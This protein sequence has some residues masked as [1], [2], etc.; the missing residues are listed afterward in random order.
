MTST[1][2]EKHAGQMRA[3]VHERYGPPDVLHVELVAQPSPGPDQLLVEVHACTVN[4]T[5]C[6]FRAAKPFIVRFFSGL[7]RPKKRILGTEFAGVVEAVGGAVTD[8]AVGDRVFGVNADV[9]GTQAEYV[10]VNQDAPV[11][12]MPAGVSFAEAAAL[13]D[14]AILALAYLRQAA[15]GPST[16]IVVYGASG[17]IGSAAVQL[18]KHFGAE[19]TAVCGA[20]HVELVRSLGADTV[21]DYRH[22]DFTETSDPYDVVFDAVGKLSFA[23]CRKAL[24]DGGMYLSTDLGPWQQNPALALWTK[25]FGRKRVAFPLPRYTKADVELTKHLVESGEYR[26]VVDRHYPLEQVVAATRYVESETKTGSVVLCIAE[27]ADTTPD[28]G[29]RAQLPEGCG[30]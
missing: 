11:A 5:D 21:L 24:K 15:V 17:S 6:G 20:E 8:F 16:R 13:G 12:M 4:R 19:V 1:E 7:V 22:E 3:V 23:R 29:K 2:S 30:P 28:P 27:D 26:A 9:F 18:A 25:H 14:G 10:L